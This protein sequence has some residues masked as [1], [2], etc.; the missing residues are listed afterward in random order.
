[1]QI[2][3]VR[4]VI[5][6]QV[7][8]LVLHRADPLAQVIALPHQAAMLPLPRRGPVSLGDHVQGQELRQHPGIQPVTLAG[9]LGNDAQLLGTAQPQTLT[10]RSQQLPQP[11]VAGRGLDHRLKRAELDEELPDLL[12]ER[13]MQRFPK[14]H[15][16]LLVDDTNRDTLLVEVDADVAHGS[17]LC[18]N[19]LKGN[20]H[21][22]PVYHDFKSTATR[23]D[24]LL[25]SFKFR[26]GL[27]QPPT[28]ATS[29]G[30]VLESRSTTTSCY[31]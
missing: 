12:W 24:L 17:L 9:A 4:I 20:N 3:P 2:R 26:E 10:Q 8:D 11:L 13:A 1:K 23:L 30:K 14:N 25:H 28:L 31:S 22:L 27:G 19:G 7:P 18:G 5:A 29:P 6:Q 16:P 15:L 21:Y